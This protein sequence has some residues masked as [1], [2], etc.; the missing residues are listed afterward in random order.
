MRIGTGFDVHPFKEGR[1]LFL[2]GVQ[3]PYKKGLLGH[4]DA[5]V[6]LH[7]I[8]DSLLGAASLGD[9]GVLF[10]DSDI[11]YKDANSL[12]L[13]CHVYDIVRKENFVLGNIDTVIMAE[14][15]KLKSY[16]PEMRLTISEALNI[17]IDQISIKAT[18]TE[19]L[20]FVGREEGIAAN[21]VVL[22]L[23]T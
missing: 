6:L 21:A 3:I 4:S 18:T 14:K 8:I 10:P 16:I 5:D 2:G 22:L 20:G 7:A 1:K 17:K 19:Q 11:Q 13:L 12:E 15:P 23:P 9:I